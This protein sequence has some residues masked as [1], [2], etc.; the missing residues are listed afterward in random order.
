MA[1]DAKQLNHFDLLHGT[2]T[3]AHAL[4]AC[5]FRKDGAGVRLEDRLLRDIVRHDPPIKTWVLFY[6]TNGSAGTLEQR[7]TYLTCRID[8]GDRGRIHSMIE[9]SDGAVRWAGDCGYCIT[10]RY[11]DPAVTNGERVMYHDALRRF[12][13]V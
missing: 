1:K 10:P 3:K 12:G 2:E 13:D 4:V 6:R 5:G 7:E 11:A 9:T 8:R